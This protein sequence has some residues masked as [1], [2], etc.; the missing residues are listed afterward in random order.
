MYGWWFTPDALPVPHSEYATARGLELLYVGIAPRKPSLAGTESNSRLRDGLTAHS[1]KDASR[2][3]L[4]LSL[5]VLLSD[6]L[7]LT[8]GAY[9]GRLN[10]GPASEEKLTRWM[11]GHARISWVIDD[12]PWVIEKELLAS[13]SLALNLD[14]RTDGFAMS[15]SE[16][17]QRFRRD[18]RA[19]AMAPSKNGT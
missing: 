17:R 1:M 7:G 9:G 3:T 18:A 4:R 12:A 16:R 10:W 15:L 19:S 13:I 11:L 5:G 6:E 2:S 8:L 14:G